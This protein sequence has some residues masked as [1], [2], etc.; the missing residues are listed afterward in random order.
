MVAAV[1]P[2]SLAACLGMVVR[3]KLVDSRG[4]FAQTIEQR[5]HVRYYWRRIRVPWFAWA[6]FHR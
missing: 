2:S 1:A 4:G 3:G 6:M 5:A